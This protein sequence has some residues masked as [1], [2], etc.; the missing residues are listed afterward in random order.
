MRQPNEETEERCWQHIAARK[1]GKAIPESSALNGEMPE[2]LTQLTA[3]ADALHAM[4]NEDSEPIVGE[5]KAR[6]RLLALIEAPA[7]PPAAARLAASHTGKSKGRWTDD[8]SRRPL[9]LLL[10]LLLV[11]LACPDKAARAQ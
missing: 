6:A 2:E 4:L 7:P 8:P 5:Q 11:L 3:L 1:H 10:A 9:L